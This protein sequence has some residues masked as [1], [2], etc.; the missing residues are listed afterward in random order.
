MHIEYELL[1]VR[2]RC[3]SKDRDEVLRIAGVFRARL[4]DEAPGGFVLEV[5]DTSDKV[6]A[7]ID[8]MRP[9]GLAEMARS[10]VVAIARGKKK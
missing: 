5:T 6:D 7:F 1:L 2:V 4:L 10:G 9:L 8:I 3:A